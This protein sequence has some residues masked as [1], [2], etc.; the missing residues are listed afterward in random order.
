[1]L[2]LVVEF[3]IATES[4]LDQPLIS[5]AYCLTVLTPRLISSSNPK[6]KCGD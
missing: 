4:K 2:V 6:S 1:M 3:I 5:E